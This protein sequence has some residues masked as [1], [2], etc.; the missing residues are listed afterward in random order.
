MVFLVGEIF[1]IACSEK[2][3]RMIFGVGMLLEGRAYTIES[4][5]RSKG[6]RFMESQEYHTGDYYYK[7]IKLI[8]TLCLSFFLPFAQGESSI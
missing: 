8:I 1:G 6:T 5:R 3:V 7:L 2:G 4:G